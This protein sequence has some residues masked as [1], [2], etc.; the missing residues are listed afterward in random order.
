[1]WEWA[2]LDY[3]TSC[4]DQFPTRPGQNQSRKFDESEAV[5]LLLNLV[6][7]T[8]GTHDETAREIVRKLDSHATNT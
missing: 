8:R 6:G 7:K 1:M 2:D 4:S 5:D 3:C